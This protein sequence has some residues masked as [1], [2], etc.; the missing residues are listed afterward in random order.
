MKHVSSARLV[1]AFL[2]LSLVGRLSAASD[3][4]AGWY[5]TI[6]ANPFPG[7]YL[8]PQNV[9]TPAAPI[10]VPVPTITTQ[11]R[12]SDVRVHVVVAVIIETDGKI[13]KVRVLEERAIDS[14][15]LKDFKLGVMQA[16]KTAKYQPAMKGGAAVRM[17]LVLPFDFDPSHPTL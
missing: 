9:D 13:R 1:A 15:R 11:E 12:V 5:A 6:R 3:P 8:E 10:V 17:V 16:L 2:T 4:A 7:V 14:T